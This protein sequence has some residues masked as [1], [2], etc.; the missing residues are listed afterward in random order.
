MSHRSAKWIAIAFT[1]ILVV[2]FGAVLARTLPSNTVE[3]LSPTNTVVSTEAPQ[4]AGGA[5]QYGDD[6]HEDAYESDDNDEHDDD[7]Y[8]DDDHDSRDGEREEHDDDD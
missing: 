7:R 1:S 2:L 5:V 8:G 4:D 3:A 6:E